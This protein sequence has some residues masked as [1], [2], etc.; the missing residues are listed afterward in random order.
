[1]FSSQRGRGRFK[2]PVSSV[3]CFTPHVSTYEPFARCIFLPKMVSGFSDS[4]PQRYLKKQ[5]PHT[6]FVLYIYIFDP[7]GFTSMDLFSFYCQFALPTIVLFLPAFNFTS[8]LYEK[9]N[10]MGFWNFKLRKSIT[11]QI[12]FFFFFILVHQVHRSACAVGL[13]DWLSLLDLTTNKLVSD[14]TEPSDIHSLI[15]YDVRASVLNVKT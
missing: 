14:D 10:K 5:S 15:T 4:Q 12:H 1:M 9:W 11:I 13:M 7:K 2:E 3:V 8:V 6:S